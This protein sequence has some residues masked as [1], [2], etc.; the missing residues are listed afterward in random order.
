VI[1]AYDNDQTLHGL[2]LYDGKDFFFIAQKLRRDPCEVVRISGDTVFLQY[3]V[4][5]REA[6]IDTAVAYEPIQKEGWRSS[7]YVL[8]TQNKIC[9]DAANEVDLE[10]NTM[11]IKNDS[12]RVIANG[13]PYN[14][15]V[16]RVIF[17]G[18]EWSVSHFVIGRQGVI[19]KQFTPIV[20][21][22]MKAGRKAYCD[23]VDEAT[24]GNV[25]DIMGYQR[26]F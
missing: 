12:M 21:R 5:S 7:K 14:F 13:K 1:S 23:Y 26:V 15:D 22:N 8:A 20:M 6:G 4:F 18:K 25:N 24:G 2:A 17:D 3:T 10:A 9:T 16:N 19:F 11:T